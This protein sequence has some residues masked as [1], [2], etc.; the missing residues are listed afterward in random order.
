MKVHVLRDLTAYYIKKGRKWVVE[1]GSKKKIFECFEL[2]I[3]AHPELME[4]PVM[5]VAKE[6]RSREKFRPKRTKSPAPIPD[7]PIDKRSEKIVSCYYCSGK[8][9]LFQ[10]VVCPNCHGEKDILVTT[11]GLG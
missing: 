11:H 4:L 2:M 6:R 3:E 1:E 10:G 5:Q 9:D 7:R 8:G